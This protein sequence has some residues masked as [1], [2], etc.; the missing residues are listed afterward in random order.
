MMT[1][2]EILNLAL[3]GTDKAIELA[4]S[5]DEPEWFIQ[6]IYR[7]KDEIRNLIKQEV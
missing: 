3:M 6:E 7:R 4:R 2:F 1:Q 5:N